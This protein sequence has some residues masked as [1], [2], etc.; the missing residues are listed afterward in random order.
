MRPFITSRQFAPALR[1][2]SMHIMHAP[3]KK[4][5]ARWERALR[6]SF[7]VWAYIVSHTS[8]RLSS[9]WLTLHLEHSTL[10]SSDIQQ[11]DLSQMGQS[12]YEGGFGMLLHNKKGQLVGPRYSPELLEE[13]A[14]LFACLSGSGDE[15][16]S[17]V[18]DMDATMAIVEAV[19]AGA[20]V[21]RMG[22]QHA[23][24][25]VRVCAC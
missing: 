1:W 14:H 3:K 15:L 9:A 10:I 25:C 6:N 2:H 5:Y 4:G 24:V 13:R 8:H 19:Q 16:A 17:I 18:R 20:Q 11:G 7:S 12:L 21:S 23:D 22:A